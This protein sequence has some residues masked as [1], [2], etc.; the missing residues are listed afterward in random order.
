MAFTPHFH[1]AASAPQELSKNYR[2]RRAPLSNS[3]FPE[4]VASQWREEAD[5][6]PLEF[7]NHN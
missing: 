6:W 7:F 5:R 1:M 4:N 3:M 2:T